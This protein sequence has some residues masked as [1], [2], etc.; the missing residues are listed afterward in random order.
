MQR[1]H[2][3]QWPEF[4]A[5]PLSLGMTQPAHHST[6]ILNGVGIVPMVQ[7]FSQLGTGRMLCFMRYECYQVCYEYF[8][9]ISPFQLANPSA[10]RHDSRGE[11]Y[12]RPSFMEAGRC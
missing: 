8:T 2:S 6:L 1:S 4:T 5:Y 10:T 3:S 9:D 12:C 11:I 7:F